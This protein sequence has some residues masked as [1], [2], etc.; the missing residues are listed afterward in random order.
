MFSRYISGNN[1]QHKRVK[2]TQP[3]L[4]EINLQ[5]GTRMVNKK[6][7]FYLGKKH[8]A[9]PPTPTDPDVKIF[10][11]DKEMIMYVITFQPVDFVGGDGNLIH[12]KNAKKAAKGLHSRGFTV[13]KDHFYIASNDYLNNDYIQSEVMF[14]VDLT[15]LPLLIHGD[16]GK[17]DDSGY[18]D[19][20]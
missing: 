3:F 1:K 7:C 6:M 16:F 9:N 13:D 14:S 10:K 15:S 4:T 2:I 12:L 8:Q 11:P 20:K 19:I 17:T 18:S 5:D